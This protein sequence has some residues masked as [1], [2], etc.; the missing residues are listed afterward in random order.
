[1]ISVPILVFLALA[2]LALAAWALRKSAYGRYFRYDRQRDQS[3]D[4]SGSDADT[5][6]VDL[7]AEG[8]HWPQ[9]TGPWD[10]ALLEITIAASSAG[11][12]QESF[13]EA[14][15]GQ[16]STRQYVE[17]AARGRRLF[18]LSGLLVASPAPGELIRLRS[19]GLNWSPESA[20]LHLFHTPITESDR[21]LIVAPHPDDAEIAAFGTYRSPETVVATVTAGDLG[22]FYLRHTDSHDPRGSALVARV[23]TWDS[24]TAPFFGGVPPE[25][26]LNLGY[27]DSTLASMHANPDTPASGPR[28]M[29]ACRRLNVSPLVSEFDP[30]PTWNSLVNDLVQLFQRIRPTLIATPHPL[31]DDHPDHV[32]TTLAVCEALQRCGLTEGRLLLYTNHSPHSSLYPVGENDGAISLPPHFGERISFSSV[33]SLP[34]S[35]EEQEWK[36]FALESHHDLRQFPSQ[37]TPTWPALLRSSLATLRNR[38]TGVD[39]RATSYFRRAVRP[40]EIF[41]VARF[42]DAAALRDEFLTAQ[43]EGRIHWNVCA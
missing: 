21:A 17:R 2:G 37:K 33:C 31:T 16:R 14:A 23:R 18:N 20:R 41:F 28:T 32:Y 11:N 25:R 3:Y 35:A 38:L 10:T 12:L 9:T 4:F 40:N 29:A 27:F 24:I 6:A 5:H 19:P 7:T 26:S 36:L 30:A 8:F 39:H 1:M 43:K 13:L 15:C 34:L 22:G 42:S